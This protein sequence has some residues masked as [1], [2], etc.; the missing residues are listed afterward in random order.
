[1]KDYAIA[2]INM[3]LDPHQVWRSHDPTSVQNVPFC[4]K[5]DFIPHFWFASFLYNSLRFPPPGYL[6]S[7]LM[8]PNLQ[9]GHSN[10]CHRAMARV[11][12][13][14]EFASKL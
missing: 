11:V 14:L 6:P 7:Y 9:G 4:E 10:Q 5:K 12:F 2:A 13:C 8:L 1:M 3:L